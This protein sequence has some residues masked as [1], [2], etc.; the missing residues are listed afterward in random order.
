MSWLRTAQAQWWGVVRHAQINRDIEEE[1]RFH[2]KMRTQENIAL[3]IDPVEASLKARRRFGNFNS[4][5]DACRDIRG[6]GALQ[7]FKQDVRFAA[8]MLLKHRVF[9]M[10]AVLALGLSV[11]AN[12]AIYTVASRVL[13]HPL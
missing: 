5:K 4:I 11:G 7:C 3:G 12:I 6:A 9:S 13:L 10:V 2:L 8:R 1:L